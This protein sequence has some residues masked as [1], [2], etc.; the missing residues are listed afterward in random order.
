MLFDR[1][2]QRVQPLSDRELCP[3]ADALTFGA[4]SRL[5]VLK[6]GSKG[7]RGPSPQMVIFGIAKI[8]VKRHGA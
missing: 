5:F 7:G 6:C 8:C 2:F 1:V 4:W 3:Y